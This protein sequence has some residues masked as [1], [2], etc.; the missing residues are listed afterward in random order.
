MFESSRKALPL[1]VLLLFGLT[2]LNCGSCDEGAISTNNGHGDAWSLNND[3]G[4]GGD[5]YTHGDGGPGDA[6][7]DGSYSDGGSGTCSGTVCG[8]EC[9]T[10]T[11]EC[12]QDHC[13]AA[14][15]GTR[16]GDDLSLCCT[17]SDLCLGGACVTPGQ[18]CERTEQCPVDSI[19][20]PTVGKCVPRSAVD[21]CEFHPPVGQ[22]TPKIACSWPT[23]LN[24]TV[25]AGRTR[26][27]NAPVVGNL[28]DD[29]GD[30]KTDTDDIPDI[31]FLSR[32]PGCCNKP[33]TLRIVSG[34]CN[35]DGSMKEIA[36]LNGAQMINDAPLALGDLTGNGV[37]ELVTISYNG[38]LSTNDH[39]NPQG[40]VAWTRTKDDGSQWK[41]L[42]RNTTYPKWN[43]H[44]RGGAVV[45]LA[46]LDG[47][48]NPEVI[49][50]NVVLN[51]QT[52]AL[53]WDGLVTSGGTGGIGNNAFLGPSSAVG[54]IDLDGNQEVAAGNTLYDYDG[55][56][57][58]TYQY[59]SSNSICQGS[60]PCDGFDAM[61]N[62]DNDPEGEVVIVR[63]GQVFVLNDDGTLLWKADIP[64]QDCGTAS[65][66]RN[67]SGPPTVA[68]FDGDGHPEIGTAGADYYAVMD[69]DCDPNLHPNG[70]QQGCDPRFPGVLWAKPNQD[71]SSR[72]TASSVFDFEGDGKAEMVYADETTFRIRA[73]ADGALLYEDDTHASN[74]RIEMPVVADVDNDGNSE[75]VIPSDTDKAIKVWADSDDNWVRT[76]RIWNQ[77]SY[78][79][80]NID[81]NGHIPAHPQPN[82]RNGRLNNYRQNIQPGGVFDAPDLAVEQVGVGGSCSG[83]QTIT[84]TA[85]VANRGALGESAGV[86]VVLAVVHAGNTTNVA[87]VQTTQRLLPGQTEVVSAPFSVPAGWWQDGFKIQATIDPDGQVNECDETNNQ[88]DADSASLAV[89]RPGLEVTS[90]DANDVACDQT[91]QLPITL[92]VQNNGT[93]TIPADTPI[94]LT[95]TT[96]SATTQIGQVRTQNALNAGDSEDL[97]TTW[98][99]PARFI[100]VPFDVTATVDPDGE[101]FQ[102]AQKNTASTSAQCIPGG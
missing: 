37:P 43:V 16:C 55:T 60:L 31:A 33:A 65:A 40:T 91:Q 75:V 52:G 66:K 14:C 11:D 22:F 85:T 34:A 79:V 38:P 32:T 71:C 97:S 6:T 99:I 10:G 8:S 30:G 39:Q 50:G 62:F 58:W 80:T 47:D 73:G 48:G 59:T 90:L 25:N 35:P 29:N 101:V 69:M 49:I 51:G 68:D 26:V 53:K 78:S 54:D 5:A 70:V 3:G 44:T 56:V 100:G 98:N 102:C 67:E 20:E 76:R 21:V 42:W 7:T 15:A 88:L 89:G 41:V 81:E 2:S 61:A 86:K 17:G 63:R 94:G 72:A 1:L 23:G 95:A 83:A 45:N 9:C 96:S 84:L 82:W 28:T 46:D 18:D 12:V 4:G 19:C 27:V 57:L 87:T 74:T 24:L 64:W 93:D 36:S 92:T 13:L 77:H